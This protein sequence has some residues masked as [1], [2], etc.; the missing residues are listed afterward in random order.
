MSA[1]SLAHLHAAVVV[2]ELRRCGVEVFYLSPGARAIPFVLVA[3]GCF[4]GTHMQA[5]F[6]L[7]RFMDRLI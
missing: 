4:D 3:Q 1:K 6:L 2:E 7:S 5:R